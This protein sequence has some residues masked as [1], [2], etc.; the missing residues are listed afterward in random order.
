MSI[1]QQQYLHY[2]PQQQPLA[3]RIG[4]DD[5]F[6]ERISEREQKDPEQHQPNA[7]EPGRAIVGVGGDFREHG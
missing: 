6:P 3:E 7:R 4:P 5:E 2:L 1:A